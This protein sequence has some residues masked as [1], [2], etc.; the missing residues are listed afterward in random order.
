MSAGLCVSLSLIQGPAKNSE[1][2]IKDDPNTSNCSTQLL[3]LHL[4]GVN[5][6]NPI[7]GR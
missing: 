6:K 2:G 1:G 7:E 4:F 3:F 5:S